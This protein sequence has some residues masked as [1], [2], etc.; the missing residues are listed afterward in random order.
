[1][2]SVKRS[3]RHHYLPQFYLKGFTNA[4]GLL[5]VFDRLNEEFRVEPPINTALVKNW[6]TVKSKG[7]KTDRIESLLAIDIEGK[8]APIIERI[9]K[10][11][12]KLKDDE[13]EI[14]AVFAALMRTRIPAFDRE[15]NGVINTFSRWYAKFSLPTVSAVEEDLRR[16]EKETGE[17]MGDVAASEVFSMIQEDTYEIQVGR[18]GKIRLMLEVGLGLLPKLLGLDWNF[19]FAPPGAAFITTDNPFTVVPPPGHD[20]DRQDYGV[21]TPEAITVLPLSTDAC[22]SFCRGRGAVSG[23]EVDACFLNDL[24]YFV[25]A[26]CDRFV[27][28]G[29]EALLRRVVRD[30]GL[31]TRAKPSTVNSGAGGPEH[32]RV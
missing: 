13:R 6:Y 18:R 16:F 5:H 21:L 30:A 8:A 10:R 4:Q 25:A 11:D 29:D 24:N 3:Q 14:L 12:I 26:N 17:S 22:L 1:M 23:G 15:A 9:T 7:K 20:L 32:P 2:S 27:L 19:L 31:D 28:A